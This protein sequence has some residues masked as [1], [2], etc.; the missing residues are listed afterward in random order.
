MKLQHPWLNLLLNNRKQPQ[1]N[2]VQIVH[3]VRPCGA[4]FLF[5]C[6]HA[7]AN[8]PR[9][10]TSYGSFAEPGPNMTTDIRKC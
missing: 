7:L 9:R 6:R 1:V 5:E 8:I 4:W 10:C 2:K 3:K